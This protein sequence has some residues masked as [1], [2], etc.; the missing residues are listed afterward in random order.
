MADDSQYKQDDTLDG[1]EEEVDET[2]N[3][4]NSFRAFRRHLLIIS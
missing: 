3:S 1:D 2:V 4:P